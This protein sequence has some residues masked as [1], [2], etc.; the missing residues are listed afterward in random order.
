[1][2]IVRDMMGKHKPPIYDAGKASFS[3]PKVNPGNCATREDSY[4]LGS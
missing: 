4:N 2:S 1:M 3:T